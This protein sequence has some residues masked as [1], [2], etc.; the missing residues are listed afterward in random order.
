VLGFVPV[1]AR[2]VLEVGC[3]RGGFGYSLRQSNGDRSIWAIEERPEFAQEA[4]KYY[5]EMVVGTFPEALLPGAP[6]FDCVVFNDVLEHLVDPWAA[7]SASL[8]HLT[9]NG[10]VVA[11]I[12]N[13]RNLRTIFDLAV[14]G[15]W[16]YVDMGVLDRT[17]LRFFTRRGIN[18]LFGDSGYEVEDIAGIHLLG[19][20]HSPLARF[21][22][23]VVGDLAFNGFALR[24][25]PRRGGP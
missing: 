1:S 4:S 9:A 5:D 18:S 24:A 23:A 22:P 20:S 10:T 21:L 17:H 14:R 12:P 2:T 15:N 19:R 8:S 25:R 11:S 16:T 7:L 6:L 13:V 3:G